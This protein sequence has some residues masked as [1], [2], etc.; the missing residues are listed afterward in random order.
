MLDD[1]G[2]SIFSKGEIDTHRMLLTLNRANQPVFSVLRMVGKVNKK[3]KGIVVGGF[4]FRWALLGCIGFSF[5]VSSH[6][7]CEQEAVAHCNQNENPGYVDGCIRTAAQSMYRHLDDPELSAQIRED[8]SAPPGNIGYEKKIALQKCVI[9]KY[10]REKSVAAAKTDTQKAKK[11]GGDAS[12]DNRDKKPAVIATNDKS[13][14]GDRQSKNKTESDRAPYI[15]TK[16]VRIVQGGQG[17]ADA[18]KRIKN[19]CS[20]PVTVV[21]CLEAQG[22][23]NE[24]LN[25]RR[26]G[27]SDVIPP[28]R[29]QMT[30]DAIQGPWTA[31]YFVCD[32]SNPKRQTCLSP[33]EIAGAAPFRD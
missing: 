11:A 14:E 15:A 30:A 5:S 3:F 18:Y 24:C 25:P 13:A 16:C 12:I 28:H 23:I 31:W 9:A 29:Y 20:T 2:Y 4:R 7:F 32:M 33:K 27:L 17:V 6:A 8:A 26:Y 21:F 19:D 10:D 22:G 1:T